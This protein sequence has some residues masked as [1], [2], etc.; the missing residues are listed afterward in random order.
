MLTLAIDLSSTLGSAAIV[1]DGHCL[2]EQ[3]W[4]ATGRRSHALFDAVDAML[5]RTDVALPRV[6]RFV[7]GLGPGNY[8][9]LRT[10]LAAARGFAQPHATPVWGVPSA[11]ATARAAVPGPAITSIAVVGDARR[12]RVWLGEY[13]PNFDQHAGAFALVPLA[14]LPQRLPAG[15]L[16]VSA[17]WDRL[18]EP[19]SALSMP[20]VELLREP[21]PPCAALLDALIDSCGIAARLPDEF[22]E[23]VYLHPPVFI[24]PRF[25]DATKRPLPPQA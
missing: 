9:G 17:D 8:A 22:L 4:D 13:A 5:A 23:P 15:T 19:L 16:V 24:E 3:S 1:R 12:E 20:H 21:L 11:T 18:A 25:T 6:D 2:T 14:D 7:V 10:S